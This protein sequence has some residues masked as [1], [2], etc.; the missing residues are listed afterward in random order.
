ML[1][2]CS[3]LNSNAYGSQH[4][5]YHQVDIHWLTEYLIA[6][7]KFGS[8]A[9]VNFLKEGFVF[10]FKGRR[11]R[12]RWRGIGKIEGRVRW[13]KTNDCYCQ[14]QALE[15]GEENWSSQVWCHFSQLETLSLVLISQILWV[16]PIYYRQ[17]Y[18]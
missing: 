18:V 13:K 5:L 1:H 6:Y 3:D 2:H 7:F 12:N 9:Q 16:L 4:S 14:M 15:N 8:R 11:R 17:Y 10:V